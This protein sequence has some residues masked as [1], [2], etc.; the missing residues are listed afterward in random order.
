MPSSRS[1]C[2]FIPASGFGFCVYQGSLL[3][4]SLH[5]NRVTFLDEGYGKHKKYVKIHSKNH[6]KVFIAKNLSKKNNKY[7]RSD[8][9]L[10]SCKGYNLCK[11]LTLGEISKFP[12]KKFQNP[13]YES[14]RVVLCKKPLEKTLNIGEMRPFWKSAIM[15]RTI[16]FAKSSVWVK[17]H[18]QLFRKYTPPNFTIAL[19]A[20]LF[21]QLFIFR[22][23]FQPCQEPISWSMQL[24]Y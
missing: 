4:V 20:S 5:K 18:L 22:T 11:I 19:E 7:L 15:Q 14:F 13:F 8:T 24:P 3:F 9:N 16:A 12:P 17:N 2:W 10:I 23:I 21:G 1:Y 6:L